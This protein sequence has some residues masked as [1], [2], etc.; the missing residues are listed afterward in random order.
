MSKINFIYNK[1]TDFYINNIQVTSLTLD[2]STFEELLFSNLKYLLYV[3]EE[4]LEQLRKTK[5]FFIQ[6]AYG[7]I[8]IKKGKNN[9]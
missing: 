8:E 2:P 6:S 3:R 4:S 7:K 9:V 1:F 5:K